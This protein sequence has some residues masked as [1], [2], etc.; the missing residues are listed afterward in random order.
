MDPE[1]LVCYC[2]GYTE[3]DIRKDFTDNGHS[4]I[5]DRIISEKKNGKC[6][7]ATTNPKER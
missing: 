2:F 5:M 3:F 7:C 6:H 4:T 1:L